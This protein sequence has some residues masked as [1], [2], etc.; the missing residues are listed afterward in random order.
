MDNNIVIKVDNI[1]LK[2]EFVK[3]KSIKAGLLN[4]FNL[5]KKKRTKY[6]QALKD[7]SFEIHKG[8]TIGVIGSNGA[9][10][11][12]LLRVLA[13][14]FSPESG[15]VI[16]N[17]ESIS[18]LSLGTGFQPE[19]SGVENVYLN[20]LLLGLT[21]TE[22]TERLSDIVEFSG[23]G[24]F[25]NYPVKT[26]SSGMRARLGFSIVSH[27]DPDVLLIDEVLGVGDRD[28][29]SKSAARIQELVDADRTVV[30]VSHALKSIKKM[31]DKVL[32]LEKGRVIMFDETNKVLE[33][34]E[35]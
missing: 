23:I 2:Y 1:S 27:I 30:L 17:T 18:L 26:Y 4:I 7:V 14:I 9:G 13:G 11:S 19:L 16:R 6:I 33:S 29:K 20:S 21:K 34:Y 28:F 10:K 5:K 15:E 24:E 3:S 31:C 35:K 25:I 8:E 12:T 32:W 22:I